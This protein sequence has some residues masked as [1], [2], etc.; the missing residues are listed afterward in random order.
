[1]YL[2]IIKLY[3]SEI[4]QALVFWEAGDIEK[5]TSRVINEW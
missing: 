3:W 5:N 2:S 1:M 4:I